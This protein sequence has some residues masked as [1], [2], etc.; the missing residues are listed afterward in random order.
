MRATR[1]ALLLCAALVGVPA[2]AAQEKPSRDS[3]QT[4][5]AEATTEVTRCCEDEPTVSWLTQLGARLAPRPPVRPRLAVR[6]HRITL[7]LRGSESPVARF[8]PLP[9]TPPQVRR[10]RGEDD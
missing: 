2:S 8:A 6:L 4:P 10:Q 1:S 5:R 3:L 9:E 7:D